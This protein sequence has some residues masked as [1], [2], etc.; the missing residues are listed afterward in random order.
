MKKVTIQL[1]FGSIIFLCAL[2]MLYSC[3]LQNKT[4]EVNKDSKSTSVYQKAIN[5]SPGSNLELTLK[6]DKGLTKQYDEESGFHYWCYVPDVSA[7]EDLSHI[8]LIVFLH[9]DSQ[10]GNNELDKLNG[11]NKFVNLLYEDTLPKE[12][13]ECH[14]EYGAIIVAPQSS[15]IWWK[16]IDNIHR[17]KILIDNVSAKYDVD[18]NK[19]SMTGWSGGA[20][21]CWMFATRYPETLSCAVL[22][23]G[24][25]SYYPSDMK[26]AQRFSLWCVVGELEYSSLQKSMCSLAEKFKDDGGESRFTIVRNTNHSDIS[27][28][29]FKEYDILQ[30]MAGQTKKFL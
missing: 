22:I 24:Y 13:G 26:L 27:Y 5:A 15:G 3:G 16:N 7:F 8:P 21:G 25:D 29:A 1:Y 17:L 2:A 6:R 23:S 28:V 12:N 11:N 18:Q 9:G 30:W 19:I 20:A 14:S 4:F 10:C